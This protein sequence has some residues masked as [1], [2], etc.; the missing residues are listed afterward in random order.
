VQKGDRSD[1]RLSI[2]IGPRRAI[3]RGKFFIFSL[4]NTDTFDMEFEFD[5]RKSHRNKLKHGIDF[6]EARKLWDKRDRDHF[7]LSR[8]REGFA[9]RENREPFVD[10][11]IHSSRKQYS[12]YLGSPSTTK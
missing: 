8:R 10:R 11:N 9:D 6:E 2:P 5:S 7:Q 4:K 1:S 12:N 3:Y